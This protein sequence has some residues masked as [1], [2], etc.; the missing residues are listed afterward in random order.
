MQKQQLKIATR[1]SP[2]ALWQ[3]NHVSALLQQLHP[4]LEV[5]LVSMSTEGDRFL[6]APL[7]QAGGKGLFIKEL[8]QALMNGDAD[9]AVHSMKDVTVDFPEGLQLAAILPR[10]DPRDAFISNSFDSLAAL[11]EGAVVGTSSMRRRTQLLRLRPD[12]RISDLRGNVGTRLEKLDDGH[13][14]AIILA[15]AGIKRLGLDQRVRD[16]LAPQDMI[17][18]IGQGAIGIES[19]SNDDDTHALIRLLDDPLTHHLVEAERVISRR[20]YGGCQLPIAAHA[21]ATD[22]KVQMRA[23]VGRLDGSEVIRVERSG[24]LTDL[25]SLAQGVADDLLDQGADE[26]LAGVLNHQ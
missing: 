26:I 8:E 9:L 2:L 4:D 10:E 18:A 24:P 21:S 5:R 3:A 15:A 16:Y 14:A 1:E 22:D 19:R 12:L 13:Y 17:P 7:S 23:M 11:P 25:G 20:L 6:S